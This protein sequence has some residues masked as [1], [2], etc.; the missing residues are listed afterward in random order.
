MKILID[1]SLPRYTLQL[2]QGY[3][4]YT[5]QY[6]G[7]GGLKN[8][9]LIRRA[10]GEFD[11]FLTADKNLRYQQNWAGRT[12]ALIIFPSNKLSVIKG[13]EQRLHDALEAVKPGMFV[14][15]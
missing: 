6:M 13:L 1:E 8:G 3:E 11:V 15:L 12:L 14:E 7:W 9:E 10:E 5:V 4:A 2:V